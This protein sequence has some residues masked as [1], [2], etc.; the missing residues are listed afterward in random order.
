MATVY[1][2]AWSAC[3]SRSGRRAG[4]LPVV[5]AWGKKGLFFLTEGLGT[6]FQKRS[7]LSK[8]LGNEYDF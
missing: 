5:R 4:Q 1:P 3:R 6:P 8:T 2:E 7:H